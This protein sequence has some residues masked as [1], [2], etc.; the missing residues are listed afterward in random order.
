MCDLQY[1]S[2]FSSV[3][4]TSLSSVQTGQRI[5]GHGGT[6]PI[7]QFPVVDKGE[8]FKKNKVFLEIIIQA[9]FLPCVILTL[10]KQTK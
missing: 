4:E 9:T 6:F 2:V 1:P 8:I 10:N 3:E 5:A 7:H